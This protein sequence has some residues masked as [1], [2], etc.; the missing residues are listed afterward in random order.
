MN[1]LMAAKVPGLVELAQKALEEG[2]CVVIGLKSTGDSGSRKQDKDGDELE[3]ANVGDKLESINSRAKVMLTK[4]LEKHCANLPDKQRLLDRAND[5]QLPANPLDDLI[6]KLGGPRKVAEM[7]SRTKRWIC[8]DG[9]YQYRDRAK[10]TTEGVN[11]KE[12][13]R[14]QKGKKLVAIIS[15]AASTG[16]SLQADR[17]A[18]NQR[19]RVHFTLELNWSADR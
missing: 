16:I 4:F 19:K 14:F 11:L 10:K 15:E 6:D 18:R 12:R 8:K 13:E 3:Y 2:K 9:V 5:L 7:T 17:T 1:M